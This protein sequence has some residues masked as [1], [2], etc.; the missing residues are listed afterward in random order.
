MTSAPIVGNHP[1]SA[2]LR[3]DLYSKIRKAK[4]KGYISLNLVEGGSLN[5]E[6]HCD[7]CP[8]ACDAFITGIYAN[9]MPLSFAVRDG[10]AVASTI[11]R[12][13]QQERD[14]RLSIEAG[15]LIL[16][17][18][19]I[20]LVVRNDFSIDTTRKFTI[21]GKLVGGRSHFESIARS[22]RST[23]SFSK[24]NI[25]QDPFR[26]IPAEEEIRAREEAEK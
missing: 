2:D 10:V 19:E 15:C 23:L 3:A 22:G 7:F 25:I 4:R 17:A 20:I 6:L 14:S 8:K 11:S 12:P 24:F 5:F 26:M 21:F 18:E 16:T 1:V 13:F 9:E